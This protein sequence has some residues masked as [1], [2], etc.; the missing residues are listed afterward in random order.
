MTTDEFVETIRTAKAAEIPLPGGGHLTIGTH[1]ERSALHEALSQALPKGTVVGGI[2]L[3]RLEYVNSNWRGHIEFLLLL[4]SCLV[5]VKGTLKEGK[6]RTLN[7]SQRLRPLSRLEDV[8][9]TTNHEEQAGQVYMRSVEL[10]ATFGGAD[11]VK[12][13]AE[14]PDV[15]I[16]L[17]LQLARQLLTTRE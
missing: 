7:F 5:S 9:V 12:L 8:T 3:A 15:E 1:A 13:T 4:D 6:R 16:K 2:Q 17:V 14:L 11:P 10:L